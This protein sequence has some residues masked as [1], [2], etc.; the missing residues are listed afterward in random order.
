MGSEPWTPLDRDVDREMDSRSGVREFRRAE[1]DARLPRS[2][3]ARCKD[4]DP[5]EDRVV[6]ILKFCAPLIFIFLVIWM[7]VQIAS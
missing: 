7:I 6:S 5:W 1:W 2:R 4:A 3:R